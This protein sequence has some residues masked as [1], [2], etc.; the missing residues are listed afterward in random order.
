LIVDDNARFLAVAHSTLENGGL[1][2][3]GTATT[4]ADALRKVAELRSDVVLVDVGLGAESGF[5]LTRLL[6]AGFPELRAGVVLISTR[7]EDDLADLIAASPA[8][9]FL[10]K[11]R[12]SAAAVLALLSAGRS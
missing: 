4:I 10:P 2:V 8:V 12:L 5:E 1:E 6:V 11:D 7:A 3:A 9:G